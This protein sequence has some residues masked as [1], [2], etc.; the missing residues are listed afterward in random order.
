MLQGTQGTLTNA[1]SKRGLGAVDGGFTGWAVSGSKR[2]AALK[3]TPGIRLTQVPTKQRLFRFGGGTAQSVETHRWVTRVGEVK[4][5]GEL[6]VVPGSLCLLLGREFGKSFQLSDNMG[7]NTLQQNGEQVCTHELE[8][9]QHIEVN[10]VLEG[11]KGKNG[12]NLEG[13]KRMQWGGNTPLETQGKL[14]AEAAGRKKQVEN[15]A[16]LANALQAEADA[17][18]RKEKEEG[19]EEGD[20]GKWE[21]PKKRKVWK[22][23]EQEKL[24]RGKV[25]EVN[26]KKKG[27]EK[28][29]EKKCCVADTG[30]KR[31]C[32]GCGLSARIDNDKSRIS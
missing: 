21:V 30:D 24:F 31:R 15:D 9:L 14:L 6:D 19:K 26:A 32:C 4:A 29:E 18:K 10:H 27:E 25:L 12:A 23:K 5:E 2:F 3:A 11:K 28:K 8:G 7:T 16:A 1:Q 22:V 13:E 20:E 17:P